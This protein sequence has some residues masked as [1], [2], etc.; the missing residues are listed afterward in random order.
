MQTDRTLC[1]VVAAIVTM[2]TISPL[3]SGQRIGLRP[4]P[5]GEASSTAPRQWN[6][7]EH[8]FT[9]KLDKVDAGPV[10][11]SYPPVYTH[12][13]YFTLKEVL[14]GSLKGGATVEASHVARQH[15]QPVFPVGKV[16]LVAANQSRGRLVIQAIEESSEN[17]LAEVTMACAMP[18]GWEIVDGK[19][20]SPW[21]PLGEKAWSATIDHNS[22]VV[23]GKTGRPALLTGGSVTFEVKPVP[24]AKEIKWTN[25]DGDGEYRITVTNPTEES[26][27]VPALLSKGDQVL[28][29]ES[30]A[31]IGQD[32][33]YPCPGCQGVAG[34]VQSTEIR[35][36]QSI[37]TVVNVLRLNGPAW[38]RGGNRIEFR[39]C[40]GEMS[41]TQSFY[42]LSRH[43]DKIREGLAQ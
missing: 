26:V 36:G 33:V 17:K 37:S 29:E 10:G 28:W 11:R 2:F 21:A 4:D 32:K 42:Y 7:A 1:A 14:R 3:V 15:D 5:G 22:K 23:C 31:I 9:A 6:E 16:C 30:L 43:H 38:P 13:L 25:P 27:G 19:T 34:E 20:V 24:P 39:F 40:L 12:K 18:M 41:G 35:P 8:V